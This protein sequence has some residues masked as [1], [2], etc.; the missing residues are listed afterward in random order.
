MQNVAFSFMR[1]CP[2]RNCNKSCSYAKGMVINMKFRPCID[3]HNG[4]VKQIVGG[5]LADNNDFAVDNFVSQADGE[6]YG[7]LYKKYKL[8]GG[9]II[10]LNPPSSEFYHADLMQ[11]YHALQAFEG[12]LQIGGGIN[13]ENAKG[14]LQWGASHVIVTSFVFKNGEIN[15]DN[16]RKLVKAVGSDKIV[17]DLSCRKRDGD[18][19]IVTDRWQKFT[20]V[21]VNEITIEILSKYCSE[22]LIHAV[23]VE[24]KAK[25]I[26]EDLADKMGQCMDMPATYAGGISSFDDLDMLRK[27]GREKIDFTIGSALDI[28][29]GNMK[30]EDIVSYGKKDRLCK[31]TKITIDKD[32]F[33]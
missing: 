24:G 26:E 13:D 3:I 32:W 31:D 4:S 7:K 28:F 10:I 12:G 9:H 8:Y 23:D 2:S 14:Y 30:F 11:S 22:F 1:Y 20:D 27:L 16:L 33:L 25:G 5:S 15:F 29:G 17:L 21:K 19:Y 6:Y 18:Y